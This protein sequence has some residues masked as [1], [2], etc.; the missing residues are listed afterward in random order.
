MDFTIRIVSRNLATQSNFIGC[1]DSWN[2]TYF[3]ARVSDDTWSGATWHDHVDA[4][5]KA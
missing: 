3:K 1:R 5:W 4:T 2:F